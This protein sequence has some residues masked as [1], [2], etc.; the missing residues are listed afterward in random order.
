MKASTSEPT[1]AEGKK[2]RK[3]RAYLLEKAYYCDQEIKGA[4]KKRRK[5]AGETE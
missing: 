1:W 4:E 5:A 3:V 2:E